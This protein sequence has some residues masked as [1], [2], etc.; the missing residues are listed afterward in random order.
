MAFRK[1][2][3]PR[4][5]VVGRKGEITFS[6]AMVIGATGAI[7]SQDADS[8]VSAS[9][10]SAGLYTLTFPTA[11]R[12]LVGTSVTILGTGAAGTGAIWEFASNNLTAGTRAGTLQVQFRRTDT[13]AAADVPNPTTLTIEVSVEEGI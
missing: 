9:R 8:G 10:V 7:S 12:K 3:F 13:M 6:H 4:K 2:P 11:Y 1:A 5:G